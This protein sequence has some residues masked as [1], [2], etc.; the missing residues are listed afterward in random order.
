SA[1]E[2]AKEELSRNKGI[3]ISVEGKI[4]NL[5]FQKSQLNKNLENLDSELES[6]AKRKQELKLK[7]EEGRKRLEEISQRLKVLQ[8]EEKSLG[9]KVE[10]LREK[11]DCLLS[12]LRR[13][14]EER[15]RVNFELKRCEDRLSTLGEKMAQILEDL[16]K[17]EGFDFPEVP[18]DLQTLNKE[19]SEIQEE[20][21]KFGEVNLKAIQ[22]YENVKARR[23][24][25]VEKKGILERERVEI[26][27]RIEKYEKRKRE[28]FF[29]VFNAIN[30]NFGEVLAELADGEGELFL[31][32]DDVFNSGL[33]I[34][35]RFK[36]KPMKRLEAISGGE[37]SLVALSLILAIQMFKPAPFYAF[38]EVDMFLDGVN[39]ERVAKMIKKRSQSAQFIVISLRKPM[40]EAADAVVGITL[41]G[42]NSSIVTG[43]RLNSEIQSKS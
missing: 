5:D 23:D 39:V 13:L 11:R 24:E 34:R 15:N 18:R 40:V 6:L 31:D 19:L 14:E 7:M 10:E 2:K 27:E 33:H 38:D 9:V 4:E 35:V 37:K 36:N 12:E 16:K 43:I 42:D 28:V 21:S 26:I 29:E 32:S 25:L 22:D 41:G 3:L 30:K 20:L 17:F 1:I 8:E